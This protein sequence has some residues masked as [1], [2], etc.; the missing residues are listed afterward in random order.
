MTRELDVHVGG[1]FDALQA[2]VSDAVE[3]DYAGISIR[4]QAEERDRK[5]RQVLAAKSDKW[6]Q[7]RP[8]GPA[9]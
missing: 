3:A 8:R 5:L 1:G 4:A 7:S 6:G 9:P 2:R